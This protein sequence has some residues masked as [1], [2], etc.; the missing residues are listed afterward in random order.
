MQ[1]FVAGSLMVALSTRFIAP[2]QAVSNGLGDKPYLGW[3]SWSLEATKYPGYGESWLSADHIKM[4][5]DV[6]HQKL[7]QHGYSYINID[8][9]WRGGWDEFG[10]P[11]PKRDKFPDGIAGV[12]QYVHARGL[13]LGIYYVPGI[14]DDL[15]K[16]NPPIQGTPYH[17]ADIV[18]KPSRPANGWGGG[19]KIDFSKPGA[20]EYIN[21]I[22]NL[23]AAWGIDFLKFDGVTPGSDHYDL[24][25]D[26]RPDVAAWGVALKR[27]SRPIWLTISWKIDMNYISYWQQYANAWR[28]N[29][30]V[31]TYQS[32]LTGWNQIT[33]RFPTARDNAK[34]AGRGQ[35]WNDLDS[36]L[37]G[38]GEMD[39]LTTD[40]RQSVMSLWAISCAPLY[41]GDDL[42]KLDDYGLSLL[43]NDEVIRVQQAGRVATLHSDV[44]KKQIWQSKQPD[45]SL[46]VALF[47]LDDKAKQ[48][49][50]ANWNDLGVPGPAMVRDL[51]SHHNLG[52]YESSF[53]AALEPHASRLLRIIPRPRP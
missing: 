35:G 26:A 25:I 6:V 21:S 13:K 52:I 45:G 7:Q 22:A 42:T 12:A 43:T 19:N 33:W 24:K 36:V 27:I 18:F 1:H 40:E 16:M 46:V 8:A 20:Q 34:Y 4:Q 49:V 23:F 3:S 48:I 2:V 17:I 14:D 5:A 10:R 39:G 50:M 31:E 9:G 32:K 15:L 51:W 41:S 44:D 29:S 11:T 37:V 28:T 38:N 53:E 47:N 30:D